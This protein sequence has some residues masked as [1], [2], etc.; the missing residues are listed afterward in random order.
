MGTGTS[1][2]KLT[3]IKSFLRADT[4]EELV[5]LQLENNTKHAGFFDYHVML[6][7]DN[8]FYAWFYIDIEDGIVG[9]SSTEE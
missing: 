7:P 6:G 5:R 8:K 9:D 4:A 2:F 3:Q 1:S